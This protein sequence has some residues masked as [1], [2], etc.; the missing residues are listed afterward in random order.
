MGDLAPATL[1]THINNRA[2]QLRAVGATTKMTATNLTIRSPS[3]SGFSDLA[4]AASDIN[5]KRMTAR[6]QG[7][8]VPTHTD[9]DTLT[10]TGMVPELHKRKLRGATD[11]VRHTDLVDDAARLENSHEVGSGDGW[12]QIADVNRAVDLILA[13]VLQ[14]AHGTR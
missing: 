14:C 1:P 12:W 9:T 2:R 8:S 11:F 13:R 7:A 10:C 4:M 3:G 5:R 6:A